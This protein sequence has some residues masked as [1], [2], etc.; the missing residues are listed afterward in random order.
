MIRIPRPFPLSVGRGTHT[1]IGRFPGRL[2]ICVPASVRWMLMLFLLLAFAV[3]NAEAAQTVVA[4][5]VGH[6]AKKPG[7][8]SARGL[9][10]FAFNRAL[11]EV[12]FSVL[13]EH[14][15]IAPIIINAPDY[16]LALRERTRAANKLSAAVFVSIHHDSVQR[17]FLSE[18]RYD[19]KSFYFSRKASG[20]SL[21]I[22]AK[23]PQYD[24]SVRLAQAVGHKMRGA[25][26]R[27]SS[28]HAED[29]DG[30]RREPVN[31]ELGIY[32]HDGLA[33]LRTSAMA[34]ILIEAGVI[35]HPE[36]EVRLAD[37]ENQL[38]LGRTIAEGIA[39]YLGGINAAE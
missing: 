29:I 5:D 4:I 27:A 37:A 18:G 11:G 7:A 28:H 17:Q 15:N 24:Q 8:T 20:Y 31:A 30:E 39:A 25:A 14:E 6:S 36:E 23:N 38:L 12:L 13:S 2:R 34:A 9:P 16:D 32:L 3:A 1:F 33:V 19:G 10:E 35:V 22:S 26:L 21:F